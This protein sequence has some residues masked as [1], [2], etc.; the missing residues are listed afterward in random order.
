MSEKLAYTIAEVVK[1]TPLS[2]SGVYREIAEGRLKAKRVGSKTAILTKDLTD[3]LASLPD[4][5]EVK[6]A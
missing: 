6:A 3:Y 5:Q 4:A 2:R 1:L